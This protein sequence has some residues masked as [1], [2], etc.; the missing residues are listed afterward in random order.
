MAASVMP[1]LR[2]MSCFPSAAHVSQDLPRRWTRVWQGQ[3]TTDDI[4]PTGASAFDS[5]D[6]IDMDDV[7]EEDE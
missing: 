4:I 7:I 6:G 2:M 1:F 5:L 3:L